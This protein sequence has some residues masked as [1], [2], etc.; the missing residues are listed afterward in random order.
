MGTRDSTNGDADETGSA[1]ASE[2][3]REEEVPTQPEYEFPPR[4]RAAKPEATQRE[5]LVNTI[6]E[7]V[8]RE[9]DEER[10]HALRIETPQRPAW[11]DVVQTGPEEPTAEQMQEL[12]TPPE[13]STPE[14]VTFF[15]PKPLTSLC[16][17]FISEL[18]RIT[19]SPFKT[20]GAIPSWRLPVLIPIPEST[21]PD[22][23][24]DS[25]PSDSG[26][27]SGEGAEATEASSRAAQVIRSA[28][29]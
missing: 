3:T 5:V 15:T 29:K 2:P 12:P 18:E 22:T 23:R 9:Q 10:S 28:A 11:L 13:G 16:P 25:E 21:D 19:R 6:V 26:R 1:G 27:T 8:V 24:D 7:E 14:P 20:P 4:R 17:S